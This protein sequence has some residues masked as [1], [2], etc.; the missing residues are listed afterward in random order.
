MKRSARRLQA[1]FL[2][3]RREVKAITG[4]RQRHI[5]EALRFLPL[6]RRPDFLGAAM[7]TLALAAVAL[8]LSQSETWGWIDVR[9]IGSLAVGGLLVVWFVQRQRVHP[10]PVLDMTLFE[11]TSFSVARLPSCMYGAL[12][13]MFRNVGALKRSRS[14]RLLVTA[15]SP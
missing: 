14:S 9:T 11:S 8:G 2:R 12:A 1:S 15:D 7:V 3:D 6:T 5:N 10:E 4:A 13:A